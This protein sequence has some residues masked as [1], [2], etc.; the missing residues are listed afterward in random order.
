MK[1]SPYI[2]FSLLLGSCSS[3]DLVESKTK[4]NVASY[5]VV[6]TLDWN[7]NIHPSDLGPFPGGTTNRNRN[8]LFYRLLR[9]FL[10][11]IGNILAT[12]PLIITEKP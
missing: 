7:E 1:I 10:S 6:V 12:N 2:L 11:Y 3:D 9:F 4:D 8:S 5:Q